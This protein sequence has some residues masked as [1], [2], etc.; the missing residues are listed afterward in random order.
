MGL[1]PGRQLVGGESGG[2]KDPTGINRDGLRVGHP[3]GQGWDA[4]IGRVANEDS[5][6]C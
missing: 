3:I 4:A 2:S 6:L 1:N 5:R